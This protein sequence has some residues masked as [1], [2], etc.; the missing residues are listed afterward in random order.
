MVFT[1][2]LN[3]TINNYRKENDS[4]SNDSHIHCVSP[5]PLRWSKPRVNGICKKTQTIGVGEEM[6]LWRVNFSGGAKNSEWIVVIAVAIVLT[7]SINIIT[8]TQL[9]TFYLCQCMQLFKIYKMYLHVVH[10]YLHKYMYL[11]FLKLN[12]KHTDK[13]KF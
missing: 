10:N 6:C 5:R 13:S 7:C 2:K 11:S 4:P 12:L 3:E 9:L 8:K 1:L